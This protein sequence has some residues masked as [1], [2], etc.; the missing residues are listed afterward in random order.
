MI[1][2]VFSRRNV[3]RAE[4]HKPDVISQPLR[5]RILFL[6]RDVLSG[7]WT[8]GAFVSPGDHTLEF[9]EQ[10]HVS[11]Q[12]L[13][14]RPRLSA[15]ARSRLEDAR[16]FAAQ[17]RAAEFLDFLDLTFKTEAIGSVLYDENVLVEAINELFKIEGAP[18]QMTPI[19][20]SR[21]PSSTGVGTTLRVVAYPKVV[22][23][24]EEVT[25]AEAI[26]PALS[27]LSGPDYEAANLEFR[28]ALD[29]YRKGHNGDCLV[30]CG[31]AFES[32]L[33]V[34]CKQNGWP[35]SPSDTAAPLLRTVLSH[36]KLEGFFEQ[37]LILIATLRNKLSTAHGGGA[38]VRS[39]EAHVAQFAISSTAAALVLWCVRSGS[40][41]AGCLSVLAIASRDSVYPAASD[42]G[43]P[44]PA[45]QFPRPYRR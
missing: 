16:A 5:N 25:F 37:P 1:F 39:A 38:T 30:K 35:F 41:S 34:L 12:Y 21:E 31:S 28:D 40:E 22:R 20:K 14:G 27:I 17:C 7:Q 19:A 36:T 44:R 42:F 11:L 29:E 10:M 4:G 6:L 23:A 13:H 32:V 45:L 43:P 3:Q 26:A 15:A 8:D 24:D 33:K 18:Y 9:W 2:D